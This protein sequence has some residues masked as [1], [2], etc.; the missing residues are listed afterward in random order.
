MIQSKV[1][2]IKM[3]YKFNICK[4]STR[5]LFQTDTN[6]I[7]VQNIKSGEVVYYLNNENKFV[8]SICLNPLNKY[9][10]KFHFKS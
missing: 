10:V 9:Q 1:F 4:N 2:F 5:Y 3:N 6:R 7:K 8:E